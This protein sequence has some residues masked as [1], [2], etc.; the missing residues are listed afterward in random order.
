M[1]ADC[2]GNGY[3]CSHGK[4]KITKYETYSLVGQKAYYNDCLVYFREGK[5]IVTFKNGP[6]VDELRKLATARK[7]EREFNC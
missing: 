1:I 7:I 2:L 3:I 6:W 5:N 4:L